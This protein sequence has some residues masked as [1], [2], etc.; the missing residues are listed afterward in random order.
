MMLILFQE[1]ILLHL[2]GYDMFKF[3]KPVWKVAVEH[4]AKMEKEYSKE[5]EEVLNRTVIYDI[6]FVSRKN[7]T[8]KI[9]QISVEN[10]G[11]VSAAVKYHDFGKV[12]LLNFASYKNPGG[13]YIDGSTS[14][15]ARICQDSFLYN[16]LSKLKDTYYAWNRNN[17]NNGLYLNRAV[18]TPDIMFTHDSVNF[19]CDVI[20]CAAPNNC[21]ARCHKEVTNADNTAAL[22][23]RIKFV[24]DIAKEQEVDTLILGAYGCGAHMQDPEEV[25]QIFREYLQKEY[26]C[27]NKVIFAIPDDTSKNFIAFKRVFN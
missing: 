21:S 13:H 23:S 6:D 10:L 15:E 19:E 7:F 3:K 22:K 20:T 26:G 4:T 2:G 18:Y 8:K 16:I 27:F 5:I 24:L 12:A 9:T 14:Q 11:T 17:L 1:R 25:A